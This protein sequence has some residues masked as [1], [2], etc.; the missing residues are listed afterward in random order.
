M[1]SKLARSLDLTIRGE[2]INIKTPL[3]IPSF[4]SKASVDIGKVL[5]ALQ[6]SI[7]ET[8]LLSAYD[9]HYQIVDMPT[10]PIAEVLFLDSG[11]YEVA[12]DFD[13][14]DPQYMDPDYPPFQARKWDISSY[15]NVLEQVNPIMPTI[16]TAFDHPDDRKPISQQVDAA[17][18]TFKQFPDLGREI[19]FKP[20]APGQDFVEISSLN[21][22]VKCF[23]DFDIIGITENELGESVLE[24]MANIARLRTT[25]NS[26]NI[27]KPIHVFGSLDPVCTPLYFLAGADIFDGLSWIRFSFLKDLA[28]YH[29]NRVQI[30]F[31]STEKEDRGLIRSYEANLHFLRDLSRNLKRYLIDKNMER[32]G[33]HHELFANSLDDLRLQVPGV[34]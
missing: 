21:S 3:L 11:G 20:E 18:K 32:L 12:K 33:A 28:I 8:L 29:K 6:P 10:G 26:E 27:E 19:L 7:T 16:V 25:M 1:S 31:G 15:R 22:V 24:R 17:I 5:D 9:I 34:V 23:K 4:S 13:T 14:M 2:T 30:D